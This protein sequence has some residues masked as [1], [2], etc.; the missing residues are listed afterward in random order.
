MFTHMVGASHL[1]QIRDW[2]GIMIDAATDKDHRSTPLCRAIVPVTIV[3][4]HS[5]V[6]PW[7]MVCFVDVANI[8]AVF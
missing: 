1:S 5:E 8:D 4:C 7:H 3:V 6:L 2:D